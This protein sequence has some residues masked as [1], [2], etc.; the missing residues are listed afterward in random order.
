[1][2][3]KWNIVNDQS[4][5]NYNAGKEIIHNT[6]VL[7][8]N[9]CHYNNTDISV[10][11]NITIIGHQN[12]APF[13]KCTTKI[14]ETTIDEAEDLDLVMPVYNLIEYSSNYFE[15]TGN[16]WFYS[17]DEAS[18]FNED[19]ANNNNYTSFEYK[20]KLLGKTEVDG[21][22]GILKNATITMPATGLEPT[23]T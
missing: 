13:T 9:L 17:K 15:A 12:C 19:I 16:L 8:S 4:N 14:E 21:N 5:A 3:T 18:N 6:E 7:K 22:N 10:R 20:A 1:M 23:T 2:T 11:G